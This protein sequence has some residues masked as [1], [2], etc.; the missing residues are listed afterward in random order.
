MSYKTTQT[1]TS[2][3]QQ[4][5]YQPMVLSVLQAHEYI[6]TSNSD[7]LEQFLKDSR[8][9]IKLNYASLGVFHLCKFYLFLQKK[10]LLKAYSQGVAVL[11]SGIFSYMNPSDIE[12][13]MF[14]LNKISQSKQYHLPQKYTFD[15][16]DWFVLSNFELLQFSRA[17]TRQKL[18]Q[19][20]IKQFHQLARY[21]KNSPFVF[22]IKSY[23]QVNHKVKET[24]AKQIQFK[25]SARWKR[26]NRKVKKS[27]HSKTI[28]LANQAINHSF[29]SF[30]KSFI[31]HHLLFLYK[32]NEDDSSYVRTLLKMEKNHSDPDVYG[33][34]ADFYK[35]NKKWKLMHQYNTKIKHLDPEAFIVSGPV[36]MI[37]S[38]R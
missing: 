27:P 2:Y 22:L 16:D 25:H 30:Q 10:Q 5:L 17:F 26:R 23:L 24:P 37:G 6:Y 14:H 11:K 38:Q 7:K 21:S 36:P 28:R 35:K 4:E 18:H 29:S 1:L 20:D 12:Y 19:L 9:F 33:L 31:Y 8:S 15:L 32:L 34:L 13:F 3:S